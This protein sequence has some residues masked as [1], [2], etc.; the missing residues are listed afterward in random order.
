MKRFALSLA[1]LLVAGLPAFSQSSPQQEED[2]RP[3]H[4]VR[5]TLEFLRALGSGRIVEVML[6]RSP[7]DIEE[8]RRT[9]AVNGEIVKVY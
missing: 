6:I 1:V 4:K 8:F 9:Y 3:V 7:R 2:P 5:T